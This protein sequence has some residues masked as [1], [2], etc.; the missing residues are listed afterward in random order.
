MIIIKRDKSKQEFDFTK[1]ENAVKA[2]YKSCGK[3]NQVKIDEVI[4]TIKKN[5]ENLDSE[6]TVEKIQDVVENSLMK[7][8]EY[9]IAKSYIIYREE[10]KNARLLKER[11]DYMSKYINSSENAATASETDSNANVS[12]KNVANLEGEVYK[13]LNRQIQRSWMKNRLNELYPEVANQYAQDI[14]SHIIYV[15][16]E[17]TSPVPKNYCMAASLYPL[18]MNGTGEIDGVTPTP[19][20]DIQSFSGQV[21]NLV[22]LL[23]SQVKGAVALGEFF[24]A[25]NFYVVKEFGEKW[26]NHLND[27]TTSSVSNNSRTIKN[28]IRKGMKQFIYGIS[29]PAGNRSYNS[30]FTNLNLFDSQYFAELFHEFVYPDG[31]KPE[32]KAIDTLQR[33]FLELHREL[34][35]I[36]PLTFPVTTMCMVHNNNEILDKEYEELCAEELSKGS[37]FF[38]YLSDSATSISSCCRVRNELTDNTFSSTTGLT[39]VMTGSSNVITLNYNRIIQ[40]WYKSFGLYA[41]VGDESQRASPEF[42]G[43]LLVTDKKIQGFFRTYLTK[44]LERVYKYHIAYKSLLYDLED[45]GMFSSSNAGYI[46]TKKLYSTIGVIGYCEA[47]EFLGYKVGYNFPYIKFLQ[48]ILGIVQEQNKLHS[49]HDPK[50]PCIFNCEG[51]PGEN[52]AVKF[53][54]WDKADGYKVPEDQNLYSSYFFKQWDSNISVLDKLKLHGKEIAPYLSGGQACHIHLDSHPSKEQYLKLLDFNVKNGVSYTGFNIPISE[55]KDCGHVVNQPIN[56][57][58]IC[59]GENIDYWIRIIGFLRPLSSYS[60]ARYK[61]AKKRVLGHID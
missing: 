19:P 55:C 47:A 48:L 25:L 44:I 57:C 28:S 38:I 30:P 35:L 29:Q 54:N 37:S 46:Y 52:L 4:W 5:L 45:K 23:S 13:T 8:G 14:D 18:M 22:F 21:T 31:T 2:A 17:A 58:P 20:N 7:C 34:R 60:E 40:D 51:I 12:I 9:D 15:H 36:K 24:V 16:D 3:N 53:Y 39:G 26:Y 59:G 27:L 41:T 61:E 49:I 32:W 10:H 43:S 6:T 1:I 50:R 56:K 42:L 33:I 11:I